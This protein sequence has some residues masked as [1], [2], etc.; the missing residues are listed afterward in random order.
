MFPIKLCGGTVT[1]K[2]V[3]VR[4]NGVTLL[5]RIRCWSNRPARGYIT[6]ISG[7]ENDTDLSAVLDRAVIHYIEDKVGYALQPEG[8]LND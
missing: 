1:T 3:M 6:S 2:R 5:V 7:Y 8:N 4:V